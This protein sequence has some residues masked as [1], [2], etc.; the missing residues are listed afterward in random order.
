MDVLQ[1]DAR[2]SGLLMNAQ[3][4][5]LGEAAGAIA[6]PHNWASQIGHMMGLHLAKA[7]KNVPWSEDGRSVCD[8]LQAKGYVFGGP[9]QTVSNEPGLGLSINE[10]VYA[11]QCKPSERIVS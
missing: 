11:E 4:A 7:C 3:A 6:I 8:V 1:L 2:R 5:R 9:Q 10:K